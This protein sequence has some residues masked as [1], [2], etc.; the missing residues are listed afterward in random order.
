MAIKNWKLIE[1]YKNIWIWH[2]KENDYKISVLRS[3][4]SDGWTVIVS[5]GYTNIINKSFYVF[6]NALKFAKQYM[7]TN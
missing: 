6:D 5:T 2:N 1:H 7:K 3:I 4:F